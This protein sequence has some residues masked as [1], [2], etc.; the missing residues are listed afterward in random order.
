MAHNW[1]EF[2]LSDI[3]GKPINIQ[4]GFINFKQGDRTEYIELNQLRII[5]P[6]DELIKVVAL[7]VQRTDERYSIYLDF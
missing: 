4:Q 5:R 6:C 3:D 1:A 7:Q 2:M